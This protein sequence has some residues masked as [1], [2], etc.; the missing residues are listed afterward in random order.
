MENPQYKYIIIMSD[1]EIDTI[2]FNI[3]K[4]FEDSK[5]KCYNI[6]QIN[7]SFF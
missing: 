6:Y 4:I 1:M 2:I 5:V 7:K 3:Y